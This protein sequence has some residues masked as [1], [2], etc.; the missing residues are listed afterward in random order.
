MLWKSTSKDTPCSKVQALQGV[1][2]AAHELRIRGRGMRQ[3]YSVRKLRLG[4][5]FSPAKSA[6]PWSNTELMTWLCRTLPNSFN[7]SSERIAWAAGICC[8]PG[9]PACSSC[10]R[11]S[12]IFVRYDTHEQEQPAEL[13]AKVLRR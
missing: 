7:A 12:G 11:S 1:E 6:K 3:L 2:P 10:S 5:T 8:V 9:K 13:G 4:I